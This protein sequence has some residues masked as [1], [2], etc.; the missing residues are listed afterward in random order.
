MYVKINEVYYLKGL[1]S[2]S[3]LKQGECDV[4]NFA[5]FTDVNKFLDWIDVPSEQLTST[6]VQKQMS[7][8]VMS[9]STG[10][11]RNG[12]KSTNVQW[13]WA[14]IVSHKRYETKIDGEK[15]TNFEVG[16]LVSEKHVI[17]S[18]PHL[19]KEVDGKRVPVDTESLKTYFGVTNIAEFEN[20]H[21][22]VLDG[23]EKIIL[24]P[25]LGNDES[26]KFANFAIVKLNTKVPF[27]KFISPVCISSFNDDPYTLV[28][29]FAYS[30]GHGYSETGTKTKDRLYTPMRIRNKEYCESIYAYSLNAAKSKRSNYFCAGGDGRSN[31]CWDDH[32][33]YMKFNGKWYLHAFMQIAWNDEKGCKVDLPVLYET[34]GLYY[35]FIVNS[36]NEN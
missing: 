11:V 21:S 17:C 16:S 12:K 20:E 13:P 32:P 3:L 18:G 8:G 36:I 19:A 23:A 9:S 6:L 30:V 24:H 35:T 1:V 7:C 33:L 4:S 2:A 15:L 25:D 5:L 10:L 29:R 28:G 22:L 27:S 34:A 14:V 31:A 26:L